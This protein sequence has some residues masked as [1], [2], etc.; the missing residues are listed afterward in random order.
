MTPVMERA[1]VM[2]IRMRVRITALIFIALV[3]IWW[4]SD[5]R[6]RSLVYPNDLGATIGLLLA[7]VGLAIRS[8]AAGV[9]AKNCRLTVTGPYAVVRNPLYVGSF[10]VMAGMMTLLNFHLVS[11]GV[12]IPL[13][14]LYYLQIRSEETFLAK[15][16]GKQWDYYASRVPRLLPRFHLH[17]ALSSWRLAAWRKNREYRALCAVIVGVVTIE[18]GSNW[19]F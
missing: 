16:Y 5:K 13:G 10:L 15:Q 6:P 14:V 2:L 19:L 7:A 3:A 12:F 17:R 1:E 11:F 9:L 18:L 4:L 8:W